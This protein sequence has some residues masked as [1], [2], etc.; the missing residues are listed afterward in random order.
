M[1]IHTLALCN[2]Q[3]AERK[4]PQVMLY[5]LVA[6]IVAAALYGVIILIDAS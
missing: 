3:T 4:K 2:T 5:I 6:L 1:A